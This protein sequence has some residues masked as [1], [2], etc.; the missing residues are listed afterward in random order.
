LILFLGLLRL[1][2]GLLGSL[3]TSVTC[4][5]LHEIRDGLEEVTGSLSNRFDL[6]NTQSLLAYKFSLF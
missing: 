6:R 4:V 3:R 1:L 5:A 2:G